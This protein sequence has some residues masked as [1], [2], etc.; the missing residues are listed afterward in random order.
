AHNTEYGYMIYHDLII[1]PPQKSLSG[2][3]RIAAFKTDGYNSRI[4][5]FEND[6]LYGYSF[7]PYYN[8]GLRVYG[9]LRYR[10]RKNL[11]FWV[12]Y[13]SFIYTD[14]GIGSGFDRIEGNR[15]SD[16]RLQA[17]FQF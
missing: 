1:K 3:L 12:R 6:V 5:A 9:N 13:A 8:T 15:K 14:K 16:L 17:R 10:I 7:P 2:N 4:Y 11:D